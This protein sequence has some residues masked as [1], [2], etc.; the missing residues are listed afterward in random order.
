MQQ[1]GALG[2]A[3][4]SVWAEIIVATCYATSLKAL[5]RSQQSADH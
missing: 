2:D 3:R 1:L 4:G 5:V